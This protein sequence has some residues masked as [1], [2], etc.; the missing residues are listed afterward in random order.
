[1][2]G[3]LA[4]ISMF[5]GNF[6]PRFWAFCHGQ[7]LPI[8]SNTALFSLLG[9]TYGG[10]GQTTFAL[11]DLRSR[12]PIGVGTGPGLSNVVLGQSFGAE[13]RTLSTANMPAHNH[14]ATVQ[15]GSRSS[16]ATSDEAAGNV[17]CNAGPDLYAAPSAANGSLAPAGTLTIQNTGSNV[18]FS[19]M[20]PVLGLNFVICMAGS[21][22]SRN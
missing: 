17:P 9:T 6:A 7:L 11:P 20:Q 3:T 21:F 10:N 15:V 18:P 12:V 5:A 2:E 19:V 1:M 16:G 13:T 22:P 8:A 4:Q 14:T